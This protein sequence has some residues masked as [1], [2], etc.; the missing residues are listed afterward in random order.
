MGSELRPLVSAPQKWEVSQ[1]NWP[2][3]SLDTI[4]MPKGADDN[5]V[6]TFSGVYTLGFLIWHQENLGH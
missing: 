6:A 5:E 3:K 1:D 4:P 2:G